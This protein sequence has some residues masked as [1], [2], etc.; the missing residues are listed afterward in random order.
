VGGAHGVG[1][2]MNLVY[3]R[4]MVT[5]AIEGELAEVPVRPHPVFNVLVPE[6]CPGVPNEMLD[7]RLLWADPA[8]Y[9]R[10]ARELGVLFSRNFEKFGTVDEALQGAA[11]AVA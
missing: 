6:F 5:A 1:Q 10:Q 3:T 11:P 2:R 7:A 9:D 4:A 8:A